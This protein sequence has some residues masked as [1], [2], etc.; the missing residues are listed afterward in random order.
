MAQYNEWFGIA[1]YLP[2]ALLHC[3]V[4]FTITYHGI[5]MARLVHPEL[6][7]HKPMLYERDTSWCPLII[8]W[9]IWNS[10]LFL[11]RLFLFSVLLYHYMFWWQDCFPATFLDHFWSHL[12]F[13]LFPVAALHIYSRSFCV[14]IICFDDKIV[15]LWLL[16]ANTTPVKI[17]GS[18]QSHLALDNYLFSS[19]FKGLM[20]RTTTNIT[21]VQENTPV[22]TFRTTVLRKSHHWFAVVVTQLR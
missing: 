19:V 1:N 11:W 13:Y 17:I 18:M 9:A 2:E 21:I 4:A 8:S 12:E 3:Q 5:Q 22:P 20:I 6:F 14:V 15:F 10:S 16:D 7:Q